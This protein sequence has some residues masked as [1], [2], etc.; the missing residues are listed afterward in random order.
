MTQGAVAFIR[1]AA[2][3]IWE[4]LSISVNKKQGH[5]P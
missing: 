2:L 3:T 5:R 1:I 4:K